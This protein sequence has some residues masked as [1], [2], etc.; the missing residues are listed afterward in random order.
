M[1]EGVEVEVGAVPL[2]AGAMLRRAREA[3][4]MHIGALA[5]T[6]KIPVKKLEALEADQLDQLHDA[7]FVRA[8]AS[9]M[10][11]TLHIDPTP[12]LERLPD[13]KKPQFQ[14]DERGLN[15]PFRVAGEQ[16]SLSLRPLLTS[17]AAVIVFLLLVAALVVYLFPEIRHRELVAET[18]A[19]PVVAEESRSPAT[20][21]SSV[22]QETV[23]AAPPVVAPPVASNA[24]EPE[25]MAQPVQA[26]TAA[27]TPVA[28]MAVQQVA[29]AAKPGASAPAWPTDGLV[30]FKARGTSWVKVSD[31]KATVLLSKTL[32]AGEQIGVSGALPFTVVIGRSD[33]TDVLVRGQPYVLQGASKDN[34]ARFEVK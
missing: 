27:S 3:A 7:V 22:A 6:M 30:V 24:S 26:V 20:P 31:A 10:C 13:H 33:L 29:S 12:V 8:L 9:S 25:P 5:V 21:S 34:V 4:G 17:P 18:P 23:P 15:A 2:S 1:S 16:R 19:E 14:S 11:R 32:V 28:A